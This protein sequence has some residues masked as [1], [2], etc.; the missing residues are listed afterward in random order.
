ME[1]GLAEQIIQVNFQQFMVGRQEVWKDRQSGRYSC[2]C[3]L[4]KLL[5]ST[6]KVEFP[7]E[8]CYCN[9]IKAVLEREINC[10][11]PGVKAAPLP[12]KQTVEELAKRVPFQRGFGRRK[13]REE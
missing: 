5:A 6:C 7:P 9:H 8:W 12:P 2:N 3:R 4:F 10:N 13:F 1:E 11:H